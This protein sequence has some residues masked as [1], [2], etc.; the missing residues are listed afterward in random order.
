MVSQSL[1]RS[2]AKA[3]V[4]KL[5]Q[6]FLDQRGY[7]YQ[8]VKSLIA[9]VNDDLTVRDYLLGLPCEVSSEG[10]SE[11]STSALCGEFISSLALLAQENGTTKKE[12]VPFMAVLATFF[13]DMGEQQEAVSALMTSLHLD[14]E[15]A[16]SK[17]L[18]EGVVNGRINADT[19]NN[20]RVSVHASVVAD[21]VD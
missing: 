20:L 10:I 8:E 17:L 1:S 2:E 9:K 5:W 18:I 3:L 21:M 12:L 16:L 15:Y 6:Q 19:I 7:D 13:I 4:H 14:P 11:V